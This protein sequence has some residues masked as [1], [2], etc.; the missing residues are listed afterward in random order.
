M[1]E[2][3]RHEDLIS[4]PNPLSAAFSEFAAEGLHEPSAFL[5]AVM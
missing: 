2:G 3:E 5:D 4:S 1:K